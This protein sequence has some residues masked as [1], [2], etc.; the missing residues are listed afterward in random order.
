MLTGQPFT[1]R[2]PPQARTVAATAPA[3]LQARAQRFVLSRASVLRRRTTVA[4]V[5]VMAER[6]GGV[7]G[8]LLPRQLLVVV[9]E[10]RVAL[11]SSSR[12]HRV[13]MSATRHRRRLRLRCRPQHRQV[14]QSYRGPCRASAIGDHRP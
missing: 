1:A 3:L 14:A 4:A 9:A 6:A 13:P 5:A 10:L 8:L 7:G 2:R 12:A 11:S